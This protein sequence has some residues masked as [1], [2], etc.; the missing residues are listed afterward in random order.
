[1]PLKELDRALMLQGFGART[2]SSEIAALA[3]LRI[4]LS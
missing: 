4:S 2:A 1:M 3:G